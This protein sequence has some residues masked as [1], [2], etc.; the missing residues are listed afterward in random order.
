MHKFFAKIFI[1][2]IFTF[3][4]FSI[5]AKEFPAQTPLPPQ[6]QS[7]D[8]NEDEF[9][10]YETGTEEEIYDPYE[11]VNRKILVFN[12]VLDR[13]FLEYIAKGYRASVPKTGRKMIRNFLNN[14]SLPLSTLNSLAQGNVNN[15]LA[16][17]SNFLI[18][19]TL[20]VGGLFDVAGE[21]GIFYKSEDF[22]QTLGRYGSG[23]GPYL[24]L[25][26]LGPSTARDFTG[27]VTDKSIS[28]FGFN[29]LEVGGKEDFI[30]DE[31]RIGLAIMSGIDAR[32]SLIEVIDDIRKDSF[33]PYATIRSAYLQKR[34]TEIQN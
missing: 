15:G 5:S 24:M 29:F 11:K 6:Q 17:F 18:N 3:A 22:G 23:P 26:F 21:K 9:E 10:N 31:T 2:V 32:E 20:G 14:L 4:P 34:A 27:W 7:F 19:T 8:D 16:S 28:P 25:P 33:D 12:D 30:S 1:I 13:Y